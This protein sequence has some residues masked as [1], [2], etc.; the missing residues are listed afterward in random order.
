MDKDNL[1]LR[2]PRGDYPSAT[3]TM[4][5]LTHTAYSSLFLIIAPEHAYKNRLVI[6]NHSEIFI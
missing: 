5:S 1:P 6:N 3:L 4:S 2:K